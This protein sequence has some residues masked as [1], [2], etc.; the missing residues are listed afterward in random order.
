M[1]AVWAAAEVQEKLEA[2]EAT[3]TMLEKLVVPEAT[4]ATAAP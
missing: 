2:R 1:V 4:R 3:A